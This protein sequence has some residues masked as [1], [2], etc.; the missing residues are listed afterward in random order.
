MIMFNF[1]AQMYL[2][3]P[4]WQTTIGPPSVVHYKQ[5]LL[6]PFGHLLG[7]QARAVQSGTFSTNNPSPSRNR[8]R[9]AHSWRV[10]DEQLKR[11]RES[12][13]VFSIVY[14]KLCVL[15]S[16]HTLFEPIHDDESTNTDAIAAVAEVFQ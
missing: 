7:H 5:D 13:F 16:T 4:R 9:I 8:N 15:S 12:Y 14:S 10:D 2:I 3:K 1:S 11:W 6:R